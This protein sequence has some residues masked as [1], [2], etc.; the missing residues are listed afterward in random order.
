[1]R[2][3]GSL[4]SIA[5]AAIICAGLV[6]PVSAQRSAPAGSGRSAPA[7]ASA[8]ETPGSDVNPNVEVREILLRRDQ[9]LA[10]AKRNAAAEGKEPQQQ[11]R[12]LGGV[13]GKALGNNDSLDLAEGARTLLKA[14][15]GAAARAGTH[16]VVVVIGSEEDRDKVRSSLADVQSR[17]QL[18][19]VNHD[20]NN[21]Q[22]DHT[23]LKP[24]GVL[25][26]V[27][28]LTA[29]N[30]WFYRPSLSLPADRQPDQMLPL[31]A[32]SAKTWTGLFGASGD[33]ATATTGFTRS[34]SPADAS[35]SSGTGEVARAANTPAASAS[36]APASAATR[37]AAGPAAAAPA[38]SA[39][40]AASASAAT[41]VNIGDVL[42][43]KIANIK[44]TASPSDTAKTVVTLTKAEEV[45][46]IGPEKGGFVQVQGANGQGWVRLSLFNKQ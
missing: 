11:R 13:L 38:A 3:A 10:A 44:V 32:A 43:P 34:S 35:A 45:V 23:P 14:Q 25:A 33:L 16:Y 31:R 17:V 5:L 24:G 12:G 29:A 46:V 2:V 19:F 36:A 21:A 20:V 39:P 8:D 42:V 30:L 9:V 15:A 27:G 18:L 6:V 28:N 41:A 7:A 26:A 4:F 22:V 40:S 1:M 37:S